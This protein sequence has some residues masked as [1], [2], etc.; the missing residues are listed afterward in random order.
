MNII[1]SDLHRRLQL[2]MNG[3]KSVSFM[4]IKL[5][6][7]QPLKYLNLAHWEDVSSWSNY[8]SLKFVCETD[9]FHTSAVNGAL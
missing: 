5:S 7:T 3:T 1:Y 6:Y 8:A 2:N 9:R 4:R